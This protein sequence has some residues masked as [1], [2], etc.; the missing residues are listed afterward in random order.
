MNPDESTDR[1]GDNANQQRE[2]AAN[3]IRSQI[4]S[5]YNSRTYVTAPPRQAAQA[6]QLVSTSAQQRPSTLVSPRNDEVSSAHVPSPYQRTHTDA[7]QIQAEQWQQYHSAWQTYYQ[8]YYESYYLAQQQAAQQKAVQQSPNATQALA[9]DYFEQTKREQQETAPASQVESATEQQPLSKDE[10]LF[11]L[12][13]QLLERVQTSAKKVRRSRHFVPIAA[14]VGVILIFS[15]LQYNTFI[16]GTVMAYVSPGSL[17]VQN[18]VVDPSTTVA[19]SANPMLIIPKINVD[20]PVIYGAGSDY[21]SQMAAM[22]KGVVN[23]S[24]P[25]ASSHPGQIGNTAIA[26]HRSNDLLDPGDYKFIFAQLDKLVPGD[27]IYTD[28]KGVRYTYVVTKSQ[29]V[30]PS[31][32]SA[33]VYPTDKPILTLITCTPLG[34]SRYRLLVTAEQVSPDPSKAEAAPQ[35]STGSTASTI[36]GANSP[37]V[38][39]KLFGAQ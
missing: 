23:F 2:A 8:K 27:T 7:A 13:Q 17:A 3:V 37:S 31:D 14:A 25:G 16:T 39:Q 12:R 28:Y 5:L 24:I 21:N 35:D 1:S 29:T 20:A 15:F 19:V 32:V 38:L 30:D 11:N 34:T 22:Q 26:G 4:D 36:P 18:I 9:A 10:A 6:D 33:L